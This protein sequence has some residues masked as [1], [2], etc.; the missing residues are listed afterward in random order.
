MDPEAWL[1]GKTHLQMRLCKGWHRNMSRTF[2]P[3]ECF[4]PHT[5]THTHFSSSSPHTHPSLQSL[6]G[7]SHTPLGHLCTPAPA[8]AV[9]RRGPGGRCISARSAPWLP[10]GPPVLIKPSPEC[11]CSSLLV[12]G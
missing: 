11:N 1:A 4:R 8:E 7:G 10:T 12:P 6:H 9:R 2:P 3:S 5:L